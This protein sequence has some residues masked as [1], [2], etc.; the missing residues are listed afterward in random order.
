[1]AT[2]DI[3]KTIKVVAY[4]DNIDLRTITSNSGFLKKIANRYKMKNKQIAFAV[5]T[6]KA[7]TRFR[8]VSKISNLLMM[9]IPEIDTAQKHSVYLKVNETI[10]ALAD[11]EAISVRLSE[12]GD[13]VRARI[14]RIANRKRAAARRAKR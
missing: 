8:L 4:E 2:N 6:N 12:N 7:R 13:F 9:S 3:S 10:A 14:E 5:F 1:M 11:I